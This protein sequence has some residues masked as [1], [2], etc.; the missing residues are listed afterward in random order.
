MVLAQKRWIDHRFR[1]LFTFLPIT[2]NGLGSRQ[3][4]RGGGPRKQRA[5]TAGDESTNLGA[6]AKHRQGAQD[7]H[8]AHRVGP[9]M[10][11]RLAI[12]Q[13]SASV[14]V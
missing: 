2:Q 8:S 9:F 12:F 11:V 3:H 7:Q 6:T 5:R 1:L 14:A 13:L 10:F 4:S